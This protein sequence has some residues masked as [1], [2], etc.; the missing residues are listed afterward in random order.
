MIIF[1]WYV[2]QEPISSE[3]QSEPLREQQISEQQISEQQSEPLR[4]SKWIL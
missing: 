3:Q 1:S 2:Y 4:D